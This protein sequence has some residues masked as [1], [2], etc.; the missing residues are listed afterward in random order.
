MSPANMERDAN[1]SIDSNVSPGE[2]LGVGHEKAVPRRAVPRAV[3]RAA[4]IPGAGFAAR[5]GC[6]HHD[7]HGQWPIHVVDNDVHAGWEVHG[8]SLKDGDG[9]SRATSA[10]KLAWTEILA[11][12]VPVQSIRGNAG[13]CARSRNERSRKSPRRMAGTFVVED[14]AS[15]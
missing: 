12:R 11:V 1:L 14:I 8:D 9:R 4:G 6:I 7:D 13:C 15:D 5:K 2:K 3:P 10:L